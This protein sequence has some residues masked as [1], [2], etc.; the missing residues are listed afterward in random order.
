[1]ILIDPRTPNEK[2]RDFGD[3]LIYLARHK[4]PAIVQHLEYGDASLWIQG[5]DYPLAAGVEVKK[6]PD[7]VA[8]MFDGRY[9]GHQLPGMLKMY[10]YRWLLLEGPYRPD[11]NGFLVVP[12]GN[13]W[14]TPGARVMYSAFERWRMTLEIMCGVRV[15][16]T[17]DRR[18]TARFLADLY[19]WGQK[20]W[21]DHDSHLQMDESDPLLA[22]VELSKPNLVRRWAK[23]LPGIGRIRSEAV[24]AH[25]PDCLTM[26]NADQ[27]SWLRIPGLGR[28]TV[29][30]LWRAIRG[31]K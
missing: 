31:Q 25:F 14:E 3:I 9:S 6:I 26:A 21:M 20:P 5:P 30:K 7:A 8:C 11:D 13:G 16:K 22:M 27:E 17:Y 10:K 24:E 15:E 23:E 2:G 29:E 1:M 19:W 18:A 4:V 12:R 28:A